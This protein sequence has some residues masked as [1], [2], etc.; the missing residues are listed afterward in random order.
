MHAHFTVLLLHGKHAWRV[1]Q[2]DTAFRH[3]LRRSGWQTNGG[4]RIGWDRHSQVEASLFQPPMATD[5]AVLR[6]VFGLCPFYSAAG[7]GADDRMFVAGL[8]RV[9]LHP[10]HHPVEPLAGRATGR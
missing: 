3:L 9:N 7:L 8:G 1:G 2:G 4:R 5:C 6:S 10:G